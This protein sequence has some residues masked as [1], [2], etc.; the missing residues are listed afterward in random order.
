[1]RTPEELDP[2][3]SLYDFDLSEH[4]LVILDWDG[5]SGISKFVA[6]HHSDGDNKPSSI[7]VNG[8]GR[9]EG[10]AVDDAT[11]FTPY[12]QFR[13]EQGYRYRF[14]VI[15]AGFLNCPIQLSVDNHTLTV[16]SSDGSDFEAVQGTSAH[17]KPS[18]LSDDF[19]LQ[20]NRW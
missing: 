20:P 7:L 13:V 14:R 15:N 4:K 19:L 17:R 8:R 18:Q 12:A 5:D 10:F 3:Y 6:H 16:I 1:M 9:F 2:H 11:R